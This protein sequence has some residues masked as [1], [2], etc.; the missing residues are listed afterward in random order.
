M[1]LKTLDTFEKVSA[2][3]LAASVI[4]SSIMFIASVNDK[5]NANSDR[6]ERQKEKMLRMDTQHENEYHEM[7]SVLIEIRERV[8]RIEQYQKDRE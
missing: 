7:H 6:L 2:L 8:T 5:A 1:S 3:V 4:I